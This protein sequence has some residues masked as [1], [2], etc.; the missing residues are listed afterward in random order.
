MEATFNARKFRVLDCPCLL[1]CKLSSYSSR[2]SRNDYNDIKTLIFR[3]AEEI[4]GCKQEL[5]REYVEIFI[6]QGIVSRESQDTIQLF[7]RTLMLTEPS[8]SSAF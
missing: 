7:K 8:T 1:R 5:D 4:Q 3:Y 6:N 2:F